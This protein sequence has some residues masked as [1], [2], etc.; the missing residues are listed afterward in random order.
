M[1]I[2]G[3]ACGLNQLQIHWICDVI[4]EQ[5]N[6]MLQTLPDEIYV[7]D[8]QGHLNGNP[9]CPF[10]KMNQGFYAVCPFNVDIFSWW[11]K[12]LWTPKCK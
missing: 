2:H 6:S 11:W 7:M 5:D 8:L 4:F 12:Y 1:C 9:V 3:L 10:A